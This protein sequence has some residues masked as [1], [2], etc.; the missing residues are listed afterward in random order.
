MRGASRYIPT[1]TSDQAQCRALKRSRQ[2]NTSLA[3]HHHA[4]QESHAKGLQELEL[5]TRLGSPAMQ[6]RVQE[7]EDTLA[8]LQRE[9]ADMYKR[10]A[11]NT[12]RVLELLD[13]TTA[14]R[15]DMAQLASENTCLR[16]RVAGQEVRLRDAEALVGEKE[17][18]ITIL[19][20]ELHLHHLELLQR[21]GELATQRQRAEELEEENHALVER[22]VAHKQLE[23]L[24]INEENAAAAK[25]AALSVTSYTGTS[26]AESLA[27]AL[28]G[29]AAPSFRASLLD[30]FGAKRAALPSP[31]EA[32]L[33]LP[34]R[35]IF[36]TPP[37]HLSRRILTP[38]TLEVNA[39]AISRDGQMLATASSDKTVV[40]YDT[41]LG[42]VRRSLTG[43]TQSVL[44]TAFNDTGDLV[45]GTCSDGSINLWSTETARTQ[46]CVCSP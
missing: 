38:H 3:T 41:A 14:Q 28:A 7:L 35:A 17:G 44:C 21:E 45:L 13:T 26:R 36:A 20:D 46:V 43:L 19:K 16:E 15:Q 39:I 32:R 29:G 11:V 10:Q 9:Q 23:A 27:T 30:F 4:L 34:E 40:L 25:R 2:A 18:V 31:E 8:T 42:G 33:P 1:H 24:R 22:W 12:Q 6:A 37:T 5:V